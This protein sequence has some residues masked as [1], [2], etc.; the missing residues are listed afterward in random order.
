MLLSKSG[1]SDG[2]GPGPASRK[3]GETVTSEE[4]NRGHEKGY[5]VGRE[6]GRAEACIGY[7]KAL[8]VIVRAQQGK[9]ERLR[10]IAEE[11]LEKYDPLAIAEK[12]S[13]GRSR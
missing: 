6:Y 5:D 4:Y 2:G 3:K 1:R 13:S 11:A 7:R 10:E 9:A 8:Q 12:E